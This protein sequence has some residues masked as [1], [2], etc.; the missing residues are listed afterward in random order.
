MP[1]I[2]WNKDFLIG[3]QDIDENHRYLIR[4]LNETYDGFVLG[5]N[6]E[7]SFIDELF[8]CMADCFTY[9]ENVMID[10]SYSDYLVHKEEHEAFT[11]NFLKIY[12][13]YEDIN[14]F[15]KLLMFLNN[16]IYHHIRE[17]DANF[18]HF[19]G[20]QEPDEIVSRECPANSL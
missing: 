12:D 3:I 16:W 19:V 1:I 15:I 17:T 11:E 18:G 9:E 20:I 14:T 6:T 2:K 10:T 7:S 8:Q 4:L 5:I 13:N